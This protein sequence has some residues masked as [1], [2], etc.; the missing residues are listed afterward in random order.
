MPSATISK[1]VSLVK[2]RQYNLAEILVR[3]V[4]KEL[5]SKVGFANSVM[6]TA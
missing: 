4:G 5:F 2:H 3:S 1:D 6:L